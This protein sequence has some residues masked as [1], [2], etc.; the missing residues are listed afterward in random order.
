[1][2]ADHVVLDGVIFLHRFLTAALAVS[3]LGPGCGPG[4]GSTVG[5]QGHAI[6]KGSDYQGHPAVGKLTM[7]PRNAPPG[8]SSFCTASLIGEQTVLTAAHCVVDA[9]SFTFELDGGEQIPAESATAHPQFTGVGGPDDIAVVRLAQSPATVKPVHIA[10]RAP[11]VGMPLLLVGYGATS[12]Q[13]EQFCSPDS[14]AKRRAESAIGTL[15]PTQFTFGGDGGGSTCK[16]DSGGPA[17]A[18]IDGDEVQVGV[19]SRGPLPCGVEPATDTR[20]DA[21]ADWILQEAGGDVAVGGVAPQVRILAP[22]PGAE[23]PAGTLRVEVEVTDEDGD[24]AEVELL[25]DGTSAATATAPPWPLSVEPAPGSHELTVVARDA[26]GH[27]AQASVGV[28]V[29]EPPSAAPDPEGPAEPP[30]QPAAPSA[31]GPPDRAAPAL[32]GGCG[33]AGEPPGAPPLLLFLGL[34]LL[35]PRR[36]EPSDFA[37]VGVQK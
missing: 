30:P 29:A 27:T 31:A 2:S 4:A 17:F 32:Y 10:T 36:R 7:V 5:T 26:Q 37:T 23:L 20:V 14:G 33:L 13:S 6:Y 25:V 12:C 35:F 28:E 22:S 3:L 9:T 18:T 34:I 19:T 15:Q 11:S 8:A 24:I 16:G 1:M 21:Y